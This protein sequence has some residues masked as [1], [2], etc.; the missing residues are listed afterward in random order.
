M[1]TTIPQT[2][3]APEAQRFRNQYANVF[4]QRL[5][6]AL[7]DIEIG[8]IG[9]TN[10]VAQTEK[11]IQANALRLLQAIEEATRGS[12][13]P[14][15]IGHLPNLG[16]NGEEAKA[17][18]HYLRG[19]DLI[20]ANFK[21][22]Y[23]AR[24]SARGHDAIRDAHRAPDQTSPAFPAITYNYLYVETMTGSN[25]QQGTRNSQITATQTITT[26]QLVAGV[27]HLID[28]VERALPTSDLP[29]EI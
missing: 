17:A 10:V 25:V 19:K 24:V 28:Q 20:D 14:V 13:T 21:I 18:Y 2:S 1:R 16:M 9:G 26:E 5:E 23:A 3:F 8:F 29:A 22:A 27:R 15:Y 12:S 7:R 11:T 4:R 6:R